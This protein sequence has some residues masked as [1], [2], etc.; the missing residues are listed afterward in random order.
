MAS[1]WGNILAAAK[2]GG[3]VIAT[4]ALLS[5]VAFGSTAEAKWH[6]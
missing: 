3:A 4:V 1:Q 5:A 2:V 6:C